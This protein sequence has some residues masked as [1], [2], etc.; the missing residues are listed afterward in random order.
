[1]KVVMGALGSGRKRSRRTVESCLSIN[2][3]KLQKDG[4]LI[5]GC[6]GILTWHRSD[7]GKDV[8][9]I[10][11]TYWGDH[12]ELNFRAE[13][14]PVR[15][16]V[17]ITSTPCHFGG[18]RLWLQCPSCRRRVATLHVNARLFLCRQCHDLV[19]E[20][21]REEIWDRAIR[22]EKRKFAKLG[23]TKLPLVDREF[24]PPKRPKGMHRHTFQRLCKEAERAHRRQGWAYY[25]TIAGLLER[26][27]G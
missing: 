14:E 8:G 1:M 21:Q 26:C 2:L 27:G 9:S 6:S 25:K 10:S 16:T 22:A 4:L 23:M 7:S 11:F 20:V 5:K 19:Y 18:E 3:F 24:L 17:P 15:Q 13:H 12:L